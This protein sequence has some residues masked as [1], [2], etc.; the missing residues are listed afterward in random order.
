MTTP[1]VFMQASLVKDRY[2]GAMATYGNS[3]W[4]KPDILTYL[5]ERGMT[6]GEIF[7]ALNANA[8]DIGSLKEELIK[9]APGLEEEI[10]KT[11]DSYGK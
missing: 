4:F 10:V 9:I 6:R 5:Y 7:R 2:K 1:P 11:F 8:V 3:F